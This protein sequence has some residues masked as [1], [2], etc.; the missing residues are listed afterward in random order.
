MKYQ[1]KHTTRQHTLEPSTMLWLKLS[2]QCGHTHHYGS[3]TAAGPRTWYPI[4]GP[5][6]HLWHL[7][8]QNPHERSTL[9]GSSQ[10]WAAQ[11]GLS[12]ADFGQCLTSNHALWR[13]LILQMLLWTCHPEKGKESCCSQRMINKCVGTI[14]PNAY[15]SSMGNC[16]KTVKFVMSQHLTEHLRCEQ[17]CHC[18]KGSDTHMIPCH[19]YDTTAKDPAAAAFWSAQLTEVT[20]TSW[21]KSIMLGGGSLTF[22]S[23]LSTIKTC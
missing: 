15:Q 17:Q 10:T 7:P 8:Q 22:K 13:C 20:L 9:D 5:W 4:P 6:Y 11:S 21:W 1:I 3:T 16:Q 14:M 18:C 2:F 12:I 19:L 23:Q